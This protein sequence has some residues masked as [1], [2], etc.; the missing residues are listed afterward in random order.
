LLLKLKA[1]KRLML[2]GRISKAGKIKI[3][4]HTTTI[5]DEPVT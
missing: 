1:K 3:Q 4:H 5:I 2:I